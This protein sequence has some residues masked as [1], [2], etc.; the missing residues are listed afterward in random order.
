[1]S[2]FHAGDNS[3]NGK[4]LALVGD[5]LYLGRTETVFSSNHEFHVL[6]ISDPTGPLGAALGSYGT[7][8]SINDVLVRDYLSF[9]LTNDSLEILRT[10]NLSSVTQYSSVS[11]PGTSVGRA[12]DCEGN[13]LYIGS[14][15]ASGNGYIT[16]ITGS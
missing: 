6:N 15:D 3:G 13:Y 14:T 4:S 10:D 5:R 16:V 9:L 12:L 1:M 8:E 2:G 11:L 7:D